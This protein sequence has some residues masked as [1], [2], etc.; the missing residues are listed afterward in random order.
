[1]TAHGDDRWRALSPYL[2]RALD[3]SGEARVTFLSLLRS[4]QPAIAADLE[5]MLER[6]AQSQEDG[7]LERAVTD[8]PESSLAGQ[9]V[10][11]YRLHTPLGQGAMGSVWLGE[12]SDGR[13][14]GVVA[15]KLLNVNVMNR[16]GEARFRREGSILARLRHPY[17][18]QLIDVGVLPTGQPFL[19]TEHVDGERIDAYCDG[20]RL[21]IATRIQLFLHVLAAM[22]HA[23]AN[24]FVHRDL[25]PSNVLVARD[26]QVKLLDFGTAKLL[27]VD[28]AML[29]NQSGSAL[30]PEYAAPE[31]LTGGV[32]TTATDVYALGALLYV[33]LTGQHPARVHTNSP[34]ELLRAIVKT[35][36]LPASEAVVSGRA[37]RAETAADTAAK[38]ATQ[39]KRLRAQLLGDLDTIVAKALK[40][41]PT[42]RYG[43]V[44]ALADDLRRYLAHQPVTAR[45]DSVVYR[46]CKFA[47]RHRWLSAAGVVT[48]AGLATGLVVVSR[49][50]A[51]AAR[52]FVQVR[53]LA[54]RLFDIDAQLGQLPGN[55]RARQVIVETSLDY[56]QRLAPDV[57]GDPDLG[58]EVGTAYMRVARVQGVP[59]AANLGQVDHAE[60]NLRLAEQF[61]Q[62]V[63]SAQP[64]NRAALLRMA[65]IS[66]D[67]MIL[68]GLRRPDDAALPLAGVSAA[69][70]NKYLERGTVD[71]A[72]AEQVVVTLNGIANRYRLEAQ[73]DQ[74]LSLTRRGIDIASGGDNPNVKHQVGILLVGR[75][76][77]H[78]DEG[79]LDQA[80]QD[81]R[82]AVTILEPQAG[83]ANVDRT[84]QLALALA[85][86]GQTLGADV[87]VSLGRPADAIP[88]LQRAFDIVD[89]L[90]HR[91]PADADSRELLS[92]AGRPLARLL[93]RQDAQHSLDVYDH[94]LRHLAEISGNAQARRDE[95]RALVGSSL[96]LRSLGNDGEAERRLD[97]AFSRLSELKL[98]PSEQ[99]DIGSEVD[100]ALRARAESEAVSGNPTQA[101]ETYRHLLD[102]ITATKPAAERSLADATD[103]SRLYASLASL[104]HL[105]GRPDLASPI[106]TR[107]FELW[108]HWNRLHPNSP[109]VVKQM[110]EAKQ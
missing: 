4:E 11:A 22:A 78:R 69:W 68:A 51:V 61:V 8:V 65:Q 34:A 104:Y 14:A 110:A 5:V 21:P 109:F 101:A 24:L 6:H 2:D 66:H 96:V 50:R 55:N 57:R 9:V 91:D 90:V 15:V 33:L 94:V 84:R 19:I 64:A 13:V 56:L 45:T 36:P 27:E 49:D 71:P 40:K 82:E 60:R 105:A 88:F 67:R 31:Q 58:L 39:P 63:L 54:N 1:M 44:D 99:V 26:G 79:A 103:L 41:V 107:R 85:E 97:A 74:A 53:Q 73:F 108:T 17:I 98:Y 62:T 18:A 10:G 46:T 100:A 29:L 28:P 89:P 16:D 72:D 42:E 47:R 75:A 52:R 70:L 38:R 76:R 102:R 7:L 32:V 23:H 43:S 92:T 30:M 83:G 93:K 48:V 77:I 3:L 80:V 106:E 20:K 25:K 81:L 86:L 12:R 35:E 59:P 95:V 37:T 87:G